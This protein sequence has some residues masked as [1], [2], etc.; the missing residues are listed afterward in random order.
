MEILKAYVIGLIKQGL[1]REQGVGVF[2][3]AQLMALHGKIKSSHTDT[4]ESEDD[5]VDQ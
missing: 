2:N 1:A 4:S 5:S 3:R